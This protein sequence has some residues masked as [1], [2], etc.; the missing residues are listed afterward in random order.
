[1]VSWKASSARLPAFGDSLPVLYELDFQ[2]VW[3]RVRGA[4]RGGGGV[5]ATKWLYVTTLPE[6]HGV[7]CEPVW[8]V[9]C[10]VGRVP[11]AVVGGVHVK[12]YIEWRKYRTMAYPQSGYALLCSVY[13]RVVLLNP[14]RFVALCDLVEARKAATHR[15]R[16]KARNDAKRLPHGT[17]HPLRW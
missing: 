12:S 6:L 7:T 4:H 13:C 17:G 5:A 9:L 8:S 1:M 16:C 10:V 14:T 15:S 11:P 3:A 2:L